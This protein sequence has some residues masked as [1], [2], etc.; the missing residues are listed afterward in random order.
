VTTAP[1]FDVAA[2]PAGF[3]DP[4]AA[5]GAR[6]AAGLPRFSG[7]S[8]QK[9][10]AVIDAMVRC[11]ETAYANVHRGAYHLS[12]LATDAYEAARGAARAS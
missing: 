8:A 3:P 10:R 6:Q 2:H 1:A 5:A 11:M 9:P 7:A 4:V 12:E